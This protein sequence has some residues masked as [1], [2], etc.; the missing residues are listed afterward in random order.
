MGQLYISP[1]PLKSFLRKYDMS[2]LVS[3]AFELHLTLRVQWRHKFVIRNKLNYDVATLEHKNERKTSMYITS[4]EIS[5]FMNDLSILIF[6]TVIGNI[7]EILTCKTWICLSLVTNYFPYIEQNPLGTWSEY[8][9]LMLMEYSE[10]SRDEIQTR[11]GTY[12]LVMSIKNIKFYKKK[13]KICLFL[14]NWK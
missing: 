14:F 12:V 3:L 6:F 8:S 7:C 10:K 13:V 1:W 11:K 4:T 2:L 9:N 5:S